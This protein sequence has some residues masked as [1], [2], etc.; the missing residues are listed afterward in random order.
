MPACDEEDRHV[1]HADERIDV[2]DG[3]STTD[4]EATIQPV[5]DQFGAPDVQ[6]R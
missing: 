6:D 4:G 1:P 5:A 2:V 3:V